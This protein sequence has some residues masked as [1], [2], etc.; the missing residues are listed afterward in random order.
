[1]W[2]L[3]SSGLCSCH[4]ARRVNACYVDIILQGD[5]LR[6]PVS[7]LRMIATSLEKSLLTITKVEIQSIFSHLEDPEA[8]ANSHIEQ[9][10]FMNLS[11]PEAGDWAV[12][13]RSLAPISF[14]R[15]MRHSTS[16][17]RH[18]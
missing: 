11:H 8:K 13:T 9:A 5:G 17:S 7:C 2:I 15:T 4:F 3:A 6:I 1:M 14:D 12:Q 16:R 10:M 18:P